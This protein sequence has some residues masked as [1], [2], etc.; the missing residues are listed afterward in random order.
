[1]RLP[2]CLVACLLVTGWIMTLR[3]AAQTA[4]PIVP[5]IDHLAH[6]QPIA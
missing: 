6:S 5:V 2:A 1:M 4:A 3:T